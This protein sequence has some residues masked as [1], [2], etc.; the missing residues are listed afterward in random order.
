[1][2]NEDAAIELIHKISVREGFGDI[3][4]EGS[5]KAAKRSAKGQKN[6]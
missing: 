6:M 1:L 4:A 3:L 2:G 5:V